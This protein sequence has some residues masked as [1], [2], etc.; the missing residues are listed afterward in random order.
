VEAAQKPLSQ[1]QAEILR[2]ILNGGNA[3]VAP[4]LEMMVGAP[5]ENLEIKTSMLMM[6]D[7]PSRVG[8]GPLNTVRVGIEGDIEG[9]FL[10]L[11]TERDFKVLKKALEPVIGGPV[12]TVH[13]ATDYMVPDWLEDRR[14]QPEF[15]TRVRDAVGELGN[16]LF[17]A[18]LTA[19]YSRCKMATF[20]GLPQSTLPD[21]DQV[22]LKGLL[23]RYS[24]VAERV[25]LV[26]ISCSVNDGPFLIRLLMFAQPSTFLAMLAAPQK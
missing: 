8:S 10:F 4:T 5:L 25:F 22:V 15:E 12:R 6:A 1:L 17:G 2:Q 23:K 18:Y 21:L 16:V 7:V 24:Q 14:Q 3:E 19:I 26:E 13:N 20:Q 11:Q 9:D